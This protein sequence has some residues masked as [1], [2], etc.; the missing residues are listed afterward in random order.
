MA[1]IQDD[2]SV[3]SQSLTLP[4]GITIKNRIAKAPL[5]DF[6]AD[7]RDNLPNE[8]VFTVYSRWARSGC[9]LIVT[10]N[11]MVDK[12]HLEAR[13]NVSLVAGQ[14]SRLDLY[15]RFAKACKESGCTAIMQ[16][17]HGG[18][19][20]PYAVNKTPKVAVS[21]SSISKHMFGTHPV[22]MSL[23]EVHQVRHAFLFASKVAEKSGFDGVQIH[24]ADLFLLGEFLNPPNA[25]HDE[26]GGALDNRMRLLREILH[27][28]RLNCPKLAISVKIN[29][30]DYQRI[31]AP[32]EDILSILK[33][34]ESRIDLLE[35]SGGSYESEASV[36]KGHRESTVKRERYFLDF[37]KLVRQHVKIPLM[38]T[39]GFRTRSVMASVVRS[40]LTDLVGIG[41]P[42]CL[43]PEL[44]QILLARNAICDY[45]VPDSK[46]DWN[47]MPSIE[48]F[49]YSGQIQRMADGLNP[50]EDLSTS[51]YALVWTP[52]HYICE[53]STT[54]PTS[55]I[56]NVVWPITPEDT[57]LHNQL[58]LGLGAVVLYVTYRHLSRP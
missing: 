16:L 22:A 51:F 48:S 38:V 9:G 4:C 3:L 41:R 2:V 6:I 36:E 55:V 32:D 21:V 23:A 17:N 25:R 52:L 40:G 37:I 7:A 15:I 19:E 12:A 5:T 18:L 31:N 11:V 29:S 54:F 42:F 57:W 49:W 26:Y 14:E 1:D 20:T 44:P 30:T 46:H 58:Y 13:R 10:G 27:G 53:P 33:M 50:D 35:V 34:L 43:Y 28:I 56:W 8:R 47:K 39:G 24:S 45:T